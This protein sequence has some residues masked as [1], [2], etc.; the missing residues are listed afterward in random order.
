MLGI[1][2]KDSNT[3]VPQTL[4]SQKKESLNQLTSSLSPVLLV[5]SKQHNESE[6]KTITYISKKFPVTNFSFSLNI[7][8]FLPN[9]FKEE[10]QKYYSNKILQPIIKK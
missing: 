1:K 7:N 8:S 4:L 2:K 3:A 10:L 6:Y 9:N 5:I